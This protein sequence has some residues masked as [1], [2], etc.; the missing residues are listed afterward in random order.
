MD[1]ASVGGAVADG[2]AATAPAIGDAGGDTR[3]Y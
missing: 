1:G 2:E 3:G